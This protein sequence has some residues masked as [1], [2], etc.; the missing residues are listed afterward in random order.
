MPI[1]VNTNSAA[2]SANYH[3]SRNQSALQKSLTRLSK[4]KPHRSTDR[5]RRRPRGLDE[6]RKRDRS[7]SRAQKS[8]QN[9]TSFLEVQDGF[10]PQRENPQPYDRTQRLERQRDEELFG[11]PTTTGVPGPSATNLRHGLAEVQRGEHVRDNSHRR[12][13]MPKV[14][15]TIVPRQY[16][17]RLRQRRRID[18]PN[19][20]REQI[21]PPFRFDHQRV[22]PGRGQVLGRSKTAGDDV[23]LRR[24]GFVCRDRPVRISRWAFSR[25]PFRTPLRCGPTTEPPCLGC[26]SPAKK[27]ACRKPT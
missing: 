15:S 22:H 8:V 13:A 7:P 11:Q 6:T 23:L 18:R 19:G 21:T 2:A 9:A 24:D 26:V 12:R 27:W 5:R 3:L 4:R 16:G 1:T 25:R 17:E 14:Y 10:W 20:E